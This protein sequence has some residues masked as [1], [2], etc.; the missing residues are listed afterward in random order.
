MMSTDNS[1]KVWRVPPELETRIP[2]QIRKLNGIGIARC[3]IAA[4]CLLF[5]VY[6]TTQAI[7]N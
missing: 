3:V 6:E 4:G 5:A 1:N 2:R 7:R